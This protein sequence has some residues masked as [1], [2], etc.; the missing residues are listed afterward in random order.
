MIGEI[1]LVNYQKTRI[2]LA[3]IDGS[4]FTLFDRVVPKIEEQLKI[5]SEKVRCTK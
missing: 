1:F 3:Q 5:L 2:K 4:D